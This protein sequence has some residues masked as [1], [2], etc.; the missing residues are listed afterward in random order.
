[1]Q[2]RAG[3]PLFYPQADGMTLIELIIVVSVVAILMSLAVPAYTHHSLRVHRSEA[4]RLL[5]QASICQERIYASNGNYDTSR[6]TPNSDFKRYQLG[7]QSPNT[8]SQSYTAVATPIGA[9]TADACGYLSL[10]Q[11]G[12]R[13]ISATGVS[14]TK[15]WNGR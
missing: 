4:I 3:N 14:I 6:C 12:F 11:S 5:L 8:Q 15:C 9:Q 2:T 1:M 10:D 7:Y 13:G